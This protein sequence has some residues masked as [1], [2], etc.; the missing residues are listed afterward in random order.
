MAKSFKLSLKT[1]KTFCDRN[2][3]Q[4]LENE[5]L[6]QIGIPTPLGQGI[7]IRVIPQEERNMVTLAL[8]IPLQ[9]PPNLIQ[10][11]ARATSLANSGL[12]MGAWVLNH[13]KGELYFRISLP[14]QGVSF[15]DEALLFSL[16]VIV[17]TVRGVGDAFLNIIREGAPAESIMGAMAKAAESSNAANEAP[18]ES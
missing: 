8:P 5:Q 12:F 6:G 4:Y 9:V 11:V 15:N 1:L 7:M 18:A 17:G 16:N 2:E 3:I 10:E 13:A 14:V